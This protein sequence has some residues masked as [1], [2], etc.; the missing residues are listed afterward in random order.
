MLS[1]GQC[2]TLREL[3][4]P[5]QNLTFVKQPPRKTDSPTDEI[6]TSDGAIA[7]RGDESRRSVLV[8][9]PFSSRLQ[10]GWAGAQH[11][12]CGLR[13]HCAIDALARKRGMTLL[14]TG[15]ANSWVRLRQN[16]ALKSALRSMRVSRF[17]NVRRVQAFRSWSLGN[18]R[19]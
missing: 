12:V 3:F 4:S 9:R 19:G 15:Q 17:P 10:R 18:V 13:A 14:V 5:W 7:Q 6:R 1:E 11:F 16:I 2:K 8:C